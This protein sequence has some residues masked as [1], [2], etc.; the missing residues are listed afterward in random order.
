MTMWR[1]ASPVQRCLLTGAPVSPGGCVVSLRPQG[2]K[3]LAQGSGP[4]SNKPASPPSPKGYLLCF[5]LWSGLAAER[6]GLRGHFGRGRPGDALSWLPAPHAP[7]T[8]HKR[9]RTDWEEALLAPHP[10]H[11]TGW[12]GR[13]TDSSRAC[14]QPLT[15]HRPATVSP[16]PGISLLPPKFTPR[17]SSSHQPGWAPHWS[18]FTPLSAHGTRGWGASKGAA[19][20]PQHERNI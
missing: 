14:S 10:Q 12:H 19:E 13:P 9:A 11:P 2:S 6:G 4:T 1:R 8:P 15:S 3:R 17:E 20:G 5:S 7:Q 16:A 18:L